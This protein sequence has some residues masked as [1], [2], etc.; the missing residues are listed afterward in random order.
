MEPAHFRGPH[1]L[2]SSRNWRQR[3]QQQDMQ[4]QQQQPQAMQTEY[5]SKDLSPR[6]L[7]SSQW[8]TSSPRNSVDPRGWQWRTSSRDYTAAP[9]TPAQVELLNS[10]GNGGIP[11]R[12]AYF[13]DRGQGRVTRLI[14][15]DLLPPLNEIPAQEP[16]DLGMEV[17]PLLTA[18]PP[19]GS[20]NMGQRVTFQ[21][22]SSR[23]ED[24]L[25]EPTPT[26]LTTN[27]KGQ[28]NSFGA[29]C[30][31][32]GRQANQVSLSFFSFLFYPL[33]YSSFSFPQCP[34]R[35]IRHAMAEK[36]SNECRSRT[37]D[38]E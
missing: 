21:V 32:P 26:R 28:P 22:R 5:P 17:L 20:V 13:I 27:S 14:P 16:K 24:M 1:S 37:I 7:S 2:D 9:P 35:N 19:N 10:L 11:E 34:T 8:A 23:R 15:A 33:F 18:T 29:G 30:P 4:Q 3:F 36:L 25:T 38:P 31:A 12:Y 6:G